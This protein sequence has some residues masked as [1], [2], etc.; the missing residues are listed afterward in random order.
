ME[1]LTV[2]VMQNNITQIPMKTKDRHESIFE[3]EKR[4]KEEA[5]KLAELHKDKPVKKYDLK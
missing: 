1:V 5:K 2:E 3:M 4:L